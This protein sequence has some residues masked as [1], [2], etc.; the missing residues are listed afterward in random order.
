[1]KQAADGCRKI[2]NHVNQAVKESEDKQ[3]GWFFFLFLLFSLIPF[4]APQAS[5][6]FSFIFYFLKSAY[7]SSFPLC[8]HVFSLE[9]GGLP[10]ETG[11]LFSEAD[12]Q[13]HDPGAQGEFS[14]FPPF[15]FL[16]NA[17]VVRPPH[18]G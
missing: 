13:P 9:V 3:V 4:F 11:P 5:F 8:L 14:K 12:G 10:E 6:L 17:P 1:V 15:E 2:L 7:S 18:A 16:L